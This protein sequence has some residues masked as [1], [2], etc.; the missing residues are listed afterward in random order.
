[1]MRSKKNDHGDA[2]QAA[3]EKAVGQMLLRAAIFFQTQ[4]KLRVGVSNPRPYLESSRDGE[5]PRKR[6]G[7]GQ[8]SLIYDPDTP[9]AVGRKGSVTVGFL[10]PARYMVIL[11]VRKRRKGLLDTLE[12]LRPQ[13]QALIEASRVS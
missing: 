9:E 5:Y 1:M 6:T 4:H 12:S 8:G 10:E 13:L 7:F 11:E 3:L 2:A